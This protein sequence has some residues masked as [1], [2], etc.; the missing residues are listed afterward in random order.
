MLRMKCKQNLTNERSIR[1]YVKDIF[2]QEKN[3]QMEYLN[4]RNIK[5]GKKYFKM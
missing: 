4:E 2:K 1:E 3:I 5:I